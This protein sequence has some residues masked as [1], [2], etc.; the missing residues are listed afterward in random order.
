MLATKEILCVALIRLQKSIKKSLK[1]N[2]FSIDFL[3]LFMKQ[4]YNF[5]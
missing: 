1:K 2:K 4:P 5:F 3:K